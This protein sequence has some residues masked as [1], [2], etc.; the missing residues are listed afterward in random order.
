MPQIS[1]ALQNRPE[2][3]AAPDYAQESLFNTGHSVG[4]LAKELMVN[5]IRSNL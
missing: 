2:L 5:D 4:E 3:R 1:L